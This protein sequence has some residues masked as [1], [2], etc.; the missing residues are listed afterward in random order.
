MTAA[1][2]TRVRPRGGCA[3]AGRPVPGAAAA[4]RCVPAHGCRLRS[5]GDPRP[6]LSLILYAWHPCPLP[7][8]FMYINCPASCGICTLKYL[9]GAEVPQVVSRESPAA[10]AAAGVGRAASPGPA[11]HSQAKPAASGSCQQHVYPTVCCVSSQP[12]PGTSL[13]AAACAPCTLHHM[14]RRRL[15]RPPA[16][17]VGTGRDDAHGRVRYRRPHRHHRRCRVH[18]HQSGIP[19]GGQRRG[20]RRAG[21]LADAPGHVFKPAC[22]PALW[23]HC[24]RALVLYCSNAGNGTHNATSTLAWWR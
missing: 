2:A 14:L 7:A 8:G 5:P 6:R 9:H 19:P 11:W 13:P 15:P 10:S 16:G 21:G 18:R 17:P 22:L 3:P 4:L 20:E 24:L 23:W 12:S 1:N